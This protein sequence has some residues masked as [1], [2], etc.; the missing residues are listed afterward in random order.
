MFGLSKKQQSNNIE[1]KP[2]VVSDSMNIFDEDDKERMRLYKDYSDALVDTCEIVLRNND[3]VISQISTV[4]VNLTDNV[5]GIIEMNEKLKSIKDETVDLSNTVNSTSKQTIELLNDLGNDVGSN[6]NRIEGYCNRIGTASALVDKVMSSLIGNISKTA[7]MIKELEEITSQVSLLSLNASIEAARAGEAGK[8]FAIVAEE[9]NKLAAAT[10]NCT[11]VFKDN[12]DEVTTDAE[13]AGIDITSELKSIVKEGT[14]VS[15]DISNLFS[16]VTSKITKSADINSS[17]CNKLVNSNKQLVKIT[18][19]LNGAIDSL[20][21]NTDTVNDI[22]EIQMLQSSN[23]YESQKLSKR[24][25]KM[26][27]E[28]LKI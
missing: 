8:G 28:D 14:T 15:S 10:K 25:Y 27:D 12:I 20:K 16:N 17:A 19:D 18:T 22:C 21:D 7:N 3:K 11:I 9:I 2:K 4:S 1:N 13:R 24:L 5:E 6:V 23:I 26:M